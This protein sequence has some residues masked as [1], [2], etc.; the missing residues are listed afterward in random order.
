MIIVYRWAK[1]SVLPTRVFTLG[2]DETALVR[3]NCG[4]AISDWRLWHE[5]RWNS[6]KTG[7]RRR[8]VYILHDSTDM[9]YETELEDPTLICSI[10]FWAQVC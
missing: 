4:V 7:Q 5:S 2:S 9:G 8:Y 10:L 6:G 1:F 3:V